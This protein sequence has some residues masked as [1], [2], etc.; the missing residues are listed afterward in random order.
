MTLRV[1]DPGLMTLLV[2]WGRPRT[3]SLGVAVGGAADRWALA[4]GNALVGN[5]ADT[6]ALEIA[7]SGP[8]LKADCEV[9]CVLYGAPFALSTDKR[10]LVAGKTFTLHADE[11]LRI[12]ATH[13]GMRAYF[14]VH[15]GFQAPEVLGSHSSLHLLQAG[16]ELLCQPS[17]IA[18]RFI[19]SDF[20]WNRAP[21][22]LR[23][24]KG[25]QADWFSEED[26][27]SQQYEVSPASNRM[28]LRLEA[29]PLAV[30]DR[31]L[32]SE[33]V[34]PGTVQVTRNGQCIVLGVDSQT[35]GG[36]PKIA[37][38][39]SADLD[40][41]A[42]LRGG[43]RVEF[44]RV[45][46]AEAERRHEQKRTEMQEWLARLLSTHGQCLPRLPS[47]CNALAVNS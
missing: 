18:T 19:N 38:L 26:F 37:Q 43:E 31:E 27:C 13:A 44:Q 9:A 14:C 39:I 17:A 8:T 25:A 4:I 3:R 22:K 6:P 33:P 5:A 23:V 2:D 15:G 46:L 1:L 28:G 29:R 42:Q 40:K 21:R 32:I 16:G 30:P 35:I 20:V 11:R 47:F 10:R 41:L 34:C 7:L 12:E 36:Y 45:D 24:L